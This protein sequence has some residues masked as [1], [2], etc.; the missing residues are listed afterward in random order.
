MPDSE[1]WQR[2]IN[3]ILGQGQPMQFLKPRYRINM[4]M[5]QGSIRPIA[6]S[7]TAIQSGG[8]LPLP[9]PWII[10]MISATNAQ[11]NVIRGITRRSLLSLMAN[12]ITS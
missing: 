9:V 7:A 10:A 2:L 1:G 8:R 4:P 6:S 12:G 3:G 5:S 11:A